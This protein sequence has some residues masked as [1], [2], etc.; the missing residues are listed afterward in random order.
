MSAFRLAIEAGADAIEFD[1]QASADGRLV[2]LHDATLDRT[3]DGAGAVFETDWSAIERLD[4]GRWFSPDYVN[5]RVPSLGEVLRLKDVELELELKG[6]GQ[7]FVDGV[8]GEVYAADALHRVEFTSG[9]VLLLAA[10]KRAV[11]AAR[12][13]LFSMRQ[14]SWMPHSVFEHHVVGT[15]ATSGADVAHVHAANLTPQISHRLHDSGF[16]VHANDAVSLEDVGRAI[17]ADADRVSVNDVDL[18]RRVLA[19]QV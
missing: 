9:N 19:Q 11:P 12:I 8:I 18:A 14:P 2:V 6:Y 5:E 1:V 10:L 16:Q 4:A 13:G 7:Q 15:A 17:L 3:T